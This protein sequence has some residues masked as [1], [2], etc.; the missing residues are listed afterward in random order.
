MKLMWGRKYWGLV[1][2]SMILLMEVELIVYSDNEWK[3]MGVLDG[4]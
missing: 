3:G 2:G 1:W 4:W